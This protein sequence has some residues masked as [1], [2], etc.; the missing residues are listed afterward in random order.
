MHLRPLAELCMRLSPHTAPIR[1][2]RRSSL[3][4]LSVAFIASS[5]FQL[6]REGNHLIRSLC[7]SPITAPSSLLRIGP[8]QCSASVLSPR[9]C[10]HLCFSLDSGATGSCSSAREPVSASR[11]LYAGRRL[12]GHQ[13]PGRLVPGDGVTPGFDDGPLTNDASSKGSLSFVSPTHTCSRYFL[14]LFLQRC[15]VGPG[16]FTPSLSQNRT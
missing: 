12:P 10:R 13:A 3:S 15:R 11:P 2:T 5:C 4:G 1:Q 8:P 6:S 9:G 7:S 14:E 16:S